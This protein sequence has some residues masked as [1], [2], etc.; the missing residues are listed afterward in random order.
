MKTIF[1]AIALVIASP[2]VAQSTTT[3][4]GHGQQHGQAQHGQGQHAQHGQ[5][6]HQ[7][8]QHGQHGQGQHSCCADRNN[9]G[10]PDCCE[11][12]QNGQRAGCCAGHESHS[13]G[14]A[15][16]QDG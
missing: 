5:G 4:Q 13:E 3:H 8:G 1:A 2:A 11:Q 12:A 15:G 10:R 9:N 14:E 7:Q 6:Q 16:R